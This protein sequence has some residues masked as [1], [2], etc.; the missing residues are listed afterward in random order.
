MGDKIHSLGDYCFAYT[1]ITRIGIPEGITS[2]PTNAFSHCE[3]LT[4]LTLPSTLTKLDAT[5]FAWCY[6]LASVELNQG[7]LDIGTYVFNSCALENIEIPNTVRTVQAQSFGNMPTLKSVTF[8]ARINADGTVFVPDISKIAFSGA[9][10]RTNPVVFNLPWTE[11]Q[12]NAQ[13]TG[14]D[15]DGAAK[16]PGFG[17]SYY[18]LNFI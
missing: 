7:L 11:E 10:T 13:F 6:K 14:T 4:D 1:T 12:H 3:Q 2:I 8:N 18:T 15:T 5:C 16:H 9:G 17:A